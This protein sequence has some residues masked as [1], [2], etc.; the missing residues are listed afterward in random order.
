VRQGVRNIFT[1]PNSK[2]GL[3]P[4]EY[5]K[6]DFNDSLAIGCLAGRHAQTVTKSIIFS[7]GSSLTDYYG[8]YK[9]PGDFFYW[10][11][12]NM[13]LLGLV[14]FYK[15]AFGH[16]HLPLCLC[17]RRPCLWC[18]LCGT[19]IVFTHFLILSRPLP[20]PCFWLSRCM[21]TSFQ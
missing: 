17:G 19:H 3:R 11:F 15:W 7:P 12:Y 6:R 5:W 4:V 13:P 10:D 8:M 21:Q 9:L 18:V 2:N 1:C 14:T 20:T 16:L